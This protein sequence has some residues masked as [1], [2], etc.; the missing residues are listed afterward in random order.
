MTTLTGSGAREIR[1]ALGLLRAEVGCVA[2]IRSSPGWDL[3]RPVEA[4]F[5]PDDPWQKREAARSARG[6]LGHLTQDGRSEALDLAVRTVV[7]STTAPT[8]AST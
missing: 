8:P 7:S 6:R 1:T 2:S 4:T 3:E 5:V